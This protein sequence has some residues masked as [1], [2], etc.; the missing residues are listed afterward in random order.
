MFKEITR[1]LRTKIIE[2]LC[3]NDITV[4]CNVNISYKNGVNPHCRNAYFK[5]V[6][7]EGL[8]TAFYIDKK[9]SYEILG[10]KIKEL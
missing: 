3:S 4:V 2:K 9:G 1:K 5:R 10:I 6:D 7:I 8:N